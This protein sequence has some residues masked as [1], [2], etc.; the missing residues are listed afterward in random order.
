MLF[1]V[2]IFALDPVPQFEERHNQNRGR[3]G[4]THE[5]DQSRG[6]DPK[7]RA[8]RGPFVRTSAS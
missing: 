5:V 6:P 3:E 7:A 8:G 1:A 4:F 2:L